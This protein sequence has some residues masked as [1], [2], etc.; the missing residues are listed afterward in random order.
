MTG[1]IGSVSAQNK[2]AKSQ[3]QKTM[4]VEQI[5]QSIL[6]NFIS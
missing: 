1:M 2:Q 6:G 3:K 4:T 5:K